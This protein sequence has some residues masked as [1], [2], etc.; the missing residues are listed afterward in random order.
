MTSHPSRDERRQRSFVHRLYSCAVERRL[1]SIVKRYYKLGKAHLRETIYYTQ[2][3]TAH[4]LGLA[5]SFSH[6]SSFPHRPRVLYTSAVGA[7]G[8]HFLT[9][10][11]QSVDVEDFDVLIFC[12][13][14][15]SF[16]EEIFSSITV[17]REQGIKWQFM[18]KYLTPEYCEPYDFIFIWDD[19]IDPLSFSF[20]QFI[21]IMDRNRLELAQ[22]A[23]SPDSYVNVPLTAA[24]N[25]ITGRFTD[26]VENMVPVFTRKAWNKYW[27]ILENGRSCWGWQ[28]S[29]T[30]R[31][32]CRYRRMGI[33]DQEPIAH[34]RPFQSR[35]SSAPLEH[36]SYMTRHPGLKLSRRI[37]YATMR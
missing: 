37:S 6:H 35:H 5:Y 21:Q 10:L 16:D 9:T 25:G 18:K 7:E 14:D 29:G 33:V 19:D 23:V 22:P 36:K 20:H 12:Y 24:Q 32:A 15:T 2:C 28:H 31:H 34:S 3:L 27:G 17:V 1:P 13:D 26:Y 11:L 30:C 4:Y 8:K